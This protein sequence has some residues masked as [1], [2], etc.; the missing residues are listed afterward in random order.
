[1]TQSRRAAIAVMARRVHSRDVH[2]WVA[3]QLTDIE[4]AAHPGEPALD[5][6]GALDPQ[7]VT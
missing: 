1:M 2:H 6:A 7:R 5:A 3:Q 4:S